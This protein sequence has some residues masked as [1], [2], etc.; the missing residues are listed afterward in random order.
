MIICNAHECFGIYKYSIDYINIYVYCFSIIFIYP[1]SAPSP[2]M[3]MA[4]LVHETKVLSICKSLFMAI[5]ERNVMILITLWA[6]KAG[7]LLTGNVSVVWNNTQFEFTILGLNRLWRAC[8]EYM[9]L[10]YKMICTQVNTG[11][12][13]DLISEKWPFKRNDIMRWSLILRIHNI[14]W[15]G[16][17]RQLPQLPVQKH[18]NISSVMVGLVW[19]DSLAW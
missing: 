7:H 5:R 15:P 3:P 10:S 17:V 16:L 2:I 19:F 6:T 11:H 8:N 13:T 18:Q 4:Q 14:E 12:K 9:G 1:S